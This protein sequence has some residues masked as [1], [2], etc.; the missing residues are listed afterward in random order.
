MTDKLKHRTKGLLS[1]LLT[2][3]LIGVAGEAVP[4]AAHLPGGIVL[5]AQAVDQTPDA[6]F[7]YDENDDG[8][9]I[10][11]YIGN[12]TEV[13]VPTVIHGRTV[14]VIGQEAFAHCESLH[15]ILLPY[16]LTTIE[17]GAFA[18]CESLTDIIIPDTVTKIADRAFASCT[19]LAAAVLPESLQDI[20]AYAFVECTNLKTLCLPQALEEIKAFTF[21]QCTALESIVLPKNV[22]R[23]GEQA[24]GG[25]GLQEI[26][27]NDALEEIGAAA[28]FHCQRLNHVTLPSSLK[29]I[30]KDAFTAIGSCPLTELTVSGDETS[31][32]EYAVGYYYENGSRKVSTDLVLLAQEGSTAQQYA[33]VTGLTFKAADTSEEHDYRLLPTDLTLEYLFAEHHGTHYPSNKICIITPVFTPEN[34]TNKDVI[35]TSSDESVMTVEQTNPAENGVRNGVI[36]PHQYGTATITAATENGIS[37]SLL[38]KYEESRQSRLLS[39]FYIVGESVSMVI[40]E[41]YNLSSAVYAAEPLIWES[42]DETVAIVSTDGKIKAVGKGTT[43]ITARN[44]NGLVAAFDISVEGHESSEISQPSS[45]PPEPS[46]LPEPSKTPVPSEISQPSAPSHTSRTSETHEPS[47][48]SK[49]TEIHAVSEVR[50][51]VSEPTGTNTDTSLSLSSPADSQGTENIPFRYGTGSPSMPAT[52]ASNHIPFLIL[53][54]TASVILLCICVRSTTFRR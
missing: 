40:N 16:G 15:T 29:M 19:S 47:E 24:F 30:G 53:L 4:Y 45:T 42:D 2:A 49:V 28:F 46:A 43:T 39:D 38:F 36:I 50:H 3:T 1:L 26:T 8:I 54:L 35:W 37:V 14:T 32:G 7:E 12:E 41:D 51:T 31:F 5:T 11:R 10:S 25:S 13:T 34:V 9:T 20:G 22:K 17:D 33:Q 6:L 44:E 21:R 18:S 27:L 23:I 48:V 52:G